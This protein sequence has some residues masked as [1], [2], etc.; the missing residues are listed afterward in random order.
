[1]QIIK[2][3]GTAASPKGK[4][5]KRL[6]R[7]IDPSPVRPAGITLVHEPSGANIARIRPL[8]A[9]EGEGEGFEILYWSWRERWASVAPSGAIASDL[10]KA[11]AAVAARDVFWSWRR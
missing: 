8:A 4:P 3:A 7:P 11:F 1:V 2:G 10:G 5:P 9:S 6:R